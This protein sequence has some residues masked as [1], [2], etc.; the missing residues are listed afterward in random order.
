MKNYDETVESVLQRSRI[1]IKEREEKRRKMRRAIGFSASALCIGTLLIAVVLNIR[2]DPKETGNMYDVDGKNTLISNT[3]ERQNDVPSEISIKD[4]TSNVDEKDKKESEQKK[5]PA[6]ISNPGIS[7]D[8]P[9]IIWGEREDFDCGE[10]EWNGKTIGTDLSHRLYYDT[11]PDSIYAVKVQAG[12]LYDFYRYYNDENGKDEKDKFN[13]EFTYKGK[14][15]AWYDAEYDKEQEM[16]NRLKTLHFI[17]D[18]L[19]YGEQLY[20]QGGTDGYI[21]RWTKESYDEMVSFIGKELI[22]KYIVDGEFLREKLEYDMSQPSSYS[23]RQE[24]YAAIEACEKY[25]LDKAEERLKAENIQY[26]RK[27]VVY[28]MPIEKYLV[29]EIHN[30]EDEEYDEEYYYMI[31]RNEQYLIIYTTKEQ[32]A[33]FSPDYY[34]SNLVYNLARK[35]DKEGNPFEPS[36]Q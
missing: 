11:D 25:T 7:A 23:A 16:S 18:D 2:S 24:C 14:N 12:I 17:G 5:D 26:E 19:K 31:E 36:D 21:Y 10:G 27:N 1:L 13:D 30:S 34:P 22:D 28:Y 8:D 15:L 4:A 32:L 9:R 20:A 35:C 29:S 33:A 6:Q 3:S